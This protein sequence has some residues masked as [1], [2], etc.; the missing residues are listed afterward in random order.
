MGKST[1]PAT[2]VL[3][4]Q[5]VTGLMPHFSY[6]TRVATQHCSSESDRSWGRLEWSSLT[7]RQAAGLVSAYAFVVARAAI[8]D[9]LVFSAGPGV[10]RIHDGESRRLIEA[11]RKD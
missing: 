6:S 8:A 5:R 7:A 1:M 10:S 4:A 3:S 9:R 2:Q 11:V